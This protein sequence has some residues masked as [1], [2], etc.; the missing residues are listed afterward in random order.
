MTKKKTK[1]KSSRGQPT[2]YKEEYCD[3]LLQHFAEGLSFTAFA[4]RLGVHKDTLYEWC[5]HHKE[6]SDAKELGEYK[7]LYFWEKV[8]VDGATGKI[9]N[10][11]ATAYV[12][13][14]KNRFP[15]DWHDR[16]ENQEDHNKIH[17][18]KIE[19][20]GQRAQQVISMEPKK[21]EGSND[22]K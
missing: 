11:N 16:K 17:T 3:L 5:K 18:V 13:N 7:S 21:I 4:G 10:F 9:S 19:L 20:P 15:E 12:W 14:K 1:A 6:F 8:G 22:D 2:K